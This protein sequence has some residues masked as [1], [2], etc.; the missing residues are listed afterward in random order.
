MTNEP[1]T[2]GTKLS[3][4]PIPRYWPPA[5]FAI[6]GLNEFSWSGER[7]L[8]TFEMRQGAPG[9]YAV[10]LAHYQA[11]GSAG[12]RVGTLAKER[13]DERMSPTFADQLTAVADYAV[14]RLVSLTIPCPLPSE[15]PNAYSLVLSHARARA[16]GWVA[17]DR[18]TWDVDGER[19][20]PS[21][22]RFAGG[23]AAFAKSPSNTYIVALGIASEPDGLHFETITDG[24]AYGMNLDAPFDSHDPARAAR[25]WEETALRS[26]NRHGFHPD[27]TAAFS[28]A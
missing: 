24:T 2:Y 25:E 19:I 5:D 8:D 13:F 18:V 12:I 14:S 26:P 10:W 7:A 22:W 21:L 16:A 17:W 20:S 4:P 3:G 9:P 27:Q 6:Y 15:P 23:W 1:R 11:A 28:S